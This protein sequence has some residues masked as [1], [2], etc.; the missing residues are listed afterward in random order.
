VEVADKHTLLGKGPVT[1][2]IVHL[3][4]R[5]LTRIRTPTVERMGYS[6]T[7]EYHCRMLLCV[8]NML[9]INTLD[10]CRSLVFVNTWRVHQQLTAL[11]GPGQSCGAR[12]MIDIACI[13]MKII[14]PHAS[15]MSAAGPK[16]NRQDRTKILVAAIPVRPCLDTC[17]YECG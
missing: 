1:N 6:G 4:C 17:A 9:G 2:H 3:H 8:R 7:Y 12:F 11:Y 16:R 14:A 13:D 10:H 15:R 5:F